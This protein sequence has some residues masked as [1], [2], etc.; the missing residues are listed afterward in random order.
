MENDILCRVGLETVVVG[1]AKLDFQTLPSR[2]VEPSLYLV[3]ECLAEWTIAK[4]TRLHSAIDK[5]L[6]L[7][8]NLREVRW[9]CQITIAIEASLRI[10]ELG[11]RR[12]KFKPR[13]VLG[14][15][16][17]RR[18]RRGQRKQRQEAVQIPGAYQAIS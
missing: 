9:P 1:Q 10:E 12:L 6:T 16:D 13:Q 11:I 15:E 4:V 7:A 3:E 5:R 2:F 14:D 17:P 8:A 18:Q